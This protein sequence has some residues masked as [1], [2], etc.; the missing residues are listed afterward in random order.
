[1]VGL[2]V[3]NHLE[4]Y[5]FASREIF[6]FCRGPRLSEPLVDSIVSHFV[7]A[8][9]SPLRL[10]SYLQEIVLRGQTETHSINTSSSSIS[11]AT[12]IYEHNPSPQSNYPS[13]MLITRGFSLTNFVIGSS[14]LGFQIFVL[15]PWHE[16]LDEEF[17]ELRREHARLLEDTRERHREELRGIREQLEL[18]NERRG[19]SGWFW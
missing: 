19:K 5:S 1:M 11:C 13:T 17:T 3:C 4:L 16:K 2:I 6:E 8:I 14:A 7:S 18:V 12:P 15:Y 9:P 10:R